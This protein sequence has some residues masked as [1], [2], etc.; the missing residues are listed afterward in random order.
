[1]TVFH[2][3]TF[4]LAN[5]KEISLEDGSADVTG[6]RRGRHCR[7]YKTKLQTV[8]LSKVLSCVSG[9]DGGIKIGVDSLSFDASKVRIY[10]VRSIRT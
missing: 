8:G 9:G 5:E 4:S 3:K 2:R 10:M 7:H 6:V 1:M